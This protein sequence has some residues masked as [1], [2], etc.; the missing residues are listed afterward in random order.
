M[1]EAIMQQ[2]LLQEKNDNKKKRHIITL[3]TRSNEH[4]KETLKKMGL[5]F[6][7]VLKLDTENASLKPSLVSCFV[8]E[9]IIAASFVVVVLLEPWYKLVD[10]GVVAI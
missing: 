1:R 9:N 5:C 8:L 7:R 4:C 10:L 6:T 3:A 2:S